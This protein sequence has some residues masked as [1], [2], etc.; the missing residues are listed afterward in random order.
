MCVWIARQT[1]HSGGKDRDGVDRVVHAGFYG[2]EGIKVEKNRVDLLRG[3]RE[4]EEGE[5]V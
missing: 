3:K 1:R 2:S 4:R 5:C